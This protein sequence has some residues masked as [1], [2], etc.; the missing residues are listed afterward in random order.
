[1]PEIGRN[2]KN[3]RWTASNPSP[4]GQ[5]GQ[6]TAARA[7]E[8]T[9]VSF[10]LAPSIKQRLDD[11]RQADG[12]NL[13]EEASRRIEASLAA[14]DAFD[15]AAR[16]AWGEANSGLIALFAHALRVIAPIGADYLDDDKASAAVARGFCHLMKRIKSPDDAHIVGEDGPERDIDVLIYD[17]LGY[18]LEPPNTS[19][20]ARWVAAQRRRFGDELGGRLLRIRRAMKAAQEAGP[21]RE[22]AKPDPAV[23]ASWAHAI[24]EIKARRERTSE[25]GEGA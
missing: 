12:R 8:K 23:A 14:E 10:R 5:D 16:L 7:S 22:M 9:T 21:P 4:E 15:L 24:A 13:S 18:E 3:P 20:R 11:V 2:G 1:L 25:G 19:A 17:Q 6:P